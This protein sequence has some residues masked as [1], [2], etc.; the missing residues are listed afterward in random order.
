ME[1][2]IE[3]KNK[4]GVFDPLGN[5][6]RKDILDLGI[7]GVKKVNVSQVF[8]IS[9]DI[10]GS[11]IERIAGELLA[12]PITEEYLLIASGAGEKVKGRVVEIAYNPGVMDPVEESTRKAIRDMGIYGVKSLR[13]ERKY[14][15]EGKITEGDFKPFSLFK[16]TKPPIYSEAEIPATLPVA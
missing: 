1:W 16:P 15:V 11:D 14:L 6:I 8:I 4:K 13:T 3:I 2:K 5:G 10:A 12:D 9:G 7:K